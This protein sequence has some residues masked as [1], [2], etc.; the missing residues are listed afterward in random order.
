MSEQLVLALQ[1]DDET[2]FSNFYVGDNAQLIDELK[3]F[4]YF[5]SQEQFIFLWGHEAVGRSHLLQACCHELF[6]RQSQIMYLDLAEKGLSPTILQGL[7]AMQ[8]IFSG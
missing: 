1:L 2:T 6:K 5:E 3:K 7:E 4:I 8:F